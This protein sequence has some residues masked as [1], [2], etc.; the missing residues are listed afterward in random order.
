M[1]TTIRDRILALTTD[2]NF[3]LSDVGSFY[4][5]HTRLLKLEAL[6][7]A[8]VDKWDGYNDAIQSIQKPVTPVCAVRTAALIDY[9]KNDGYEIVTVI[10]RPEEIGI[11]DLS[12]ANNDCI[13]ATWEPPNPE[14]DYWILHYKNFG[15]GNLSAKIV[16][17]WARKLSSPNE[18]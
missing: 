4:H 11:T 12:Y 8:G 17:I 16:A 6:E 2:R 14:G 3:L 10:R 1:Q 5:V 18:D 15:D 9:L 13:I 7:A